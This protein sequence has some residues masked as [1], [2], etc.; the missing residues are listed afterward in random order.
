MPTKNAAAPATL[1][2]TIAFPLARISDLLSCA[3]EG[4]S[5]YWYSIEK[6]VGV[7]NDLTFRSD[8][9][10]VYRHLDYPLNEGHALM[11]SDAKAV[12]SDADKRVEQLDLAACRRG[13]EVMA[14]KY[15]QHY[16]NF[17]ADNEDAETG[18][19]FLQCALFGE[20]VYG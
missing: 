9:K 20:I 8:E 5:N 11:V 4:G 1:A 14:A 6:F 16:S 17:L 18:D 2:V 3:F 12:D 19:V 7:S 15:P 13:L 10:A